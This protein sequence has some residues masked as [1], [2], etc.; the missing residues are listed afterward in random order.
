M[1]RKLQHYQVVFLKRLIDEHAAA[2]SKSKEK[3]LPVLMTQLA[4]LLVLIDTDETALATVTSILREIS[5]RRAEWDV[6]KPC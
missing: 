4:K 5:N 3:M 1:L 6:D 2:L